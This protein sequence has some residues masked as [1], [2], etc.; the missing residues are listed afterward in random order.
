MASLDV[1]MT[2]NG[3]PYTEATMRNEIERG[4]MEAMINGIKEKISS[5][6]SP[7]E[8]Q[9]IAIDVQGSDL[10]S[11]SLSVSGPDEIVSKVRAAL[12]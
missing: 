2:I 11:L 1:K 10:S 4:V 5:V 3:E 6:V 12:G 8:A 7:H 9:Q